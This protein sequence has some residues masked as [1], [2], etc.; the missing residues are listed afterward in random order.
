[1]I[2]HWFVSQKFTNPLP[3]YE[4]LFTSPEAKLA[5][6]RTVAMHFLRTGQFETAETFLSVSPNPNLVTL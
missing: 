4:P 6:E 5:L 2:D 1:M 3:S